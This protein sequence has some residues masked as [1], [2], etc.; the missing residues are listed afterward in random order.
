MY[1]RYVRGLDAAKMDFNLCAISYKKQ[2]RFGPFGCRFQRP[3]NNKCRSVVAAHCIDCD[4]H[5]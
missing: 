1:D 2:L 3:F 4:P 5:V